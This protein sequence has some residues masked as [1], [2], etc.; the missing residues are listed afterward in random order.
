MKHIEIFPPEWK[1]KRLIKE[2]GKQF[3]YLQKPF[4]NNGDDLEFSEEP[5][6]DRVAERLYTNIGI[7]TSPGISLGITPI[8]GYK[9]PVR[10]PDYLALDQIPHAYIV[11]RTR[12]GKSTLLYNWQL[13]EIYRGNGVGI[14]AQE[15]E[16]VEQILRFLPKERLNDVDIVDPTEKYG[17]A[18][19]LNQLYF[20]QGRRI[21][22]EEDNTATIFSKLWAD[23]KE[24]QR[25]TEIFRQALAALMQIEGTTLTNLM[26]LIDRRETMYRSQ[27]V[28]QLPEGAVRN[29]WENEYDDLPKNSADPIKIRLGRFLRNGYAQKM[30]CNQAKPLDFRNI[31]DNKRILIVN[32]NDGVIGAEAS[33]IIGQL[34]VSN[35][36]IAAMARA[37][38]TKEYPWFKLF[39]DEFQEFL[40]STVS[41]EKILARGGKYK[42]YLVLSHQDFSQIPTALRKNILTNVGV[43]ISFSLGSD[44]AEAISKEFV[45]PGK[46]KHITGHKIINLQRGQAICRFK[47]GDTSIQLFTRPWPYKPTYAWKRP[48]KV[49]IPEEIP[50]IRPQKIS[51][52]KIKVEDIR[53]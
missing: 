53:L 25:A 21:V 20:H 10:L 2:T 28:G 26:R 14:L 17:T 29:F 49:D 50:Q 6:I 1:Q 31:I 22:T 18:P 4:W 27:V 52:P 3:S 48:I 7:L 19:S 15:T 51:I 33:R 35:I 23:D 45:V 5:N 37:E 30:F 34:V 41:Y 24:P 42:L 8:Q 38:M 9:M 16:Q 32:L 12:I 46:K 13:Q 40:I 11:G 39:L 43:T 44:D 36:Q 47:T